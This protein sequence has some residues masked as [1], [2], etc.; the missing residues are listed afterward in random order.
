[1]RQ[2]QVKIHAIEVMLWHKDKAC[3]GENID[4]AGSIFALGPAENRLLPAMQITEGLGPGALWRSQSD[5]A[6]KTTKP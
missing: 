3:R 6:N 4:G 5:E 2:Q 1:M